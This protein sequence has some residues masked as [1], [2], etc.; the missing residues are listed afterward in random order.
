MY[1][2]CNEL[3]VFLYWRLG[4]F[5]A[6]D[7]SSPEHFGMVTF[8]LHWRSGTWTFWGIFSRRTGTFQHGDT[9]ALGHFGTRKFWQMDVLALGNFATIQSNW[10][11]WHRHFGTCGEMCYCP[12]MFIFPKY[13]CAKMFQSQNVPVKKGPCAKISRCR[14]FP[15]PKSSHAK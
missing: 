14:N 5:S 1:T 3:V 12:K 13:L 7:I 2:T 11:F 8:W 6:P 10:T 15:V 4:L 9:T